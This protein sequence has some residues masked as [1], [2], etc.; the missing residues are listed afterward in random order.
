[1]VQNNVGRGDRAARDSC[2]VPSIQ[3][4]KTRGGAHEAH[5][6]LKTSDGGNQ[7][8]GWR[9][10]IAGRGTWRWKALA[11]TEASNNSNQASKMEV[12][13]RSVDETEPVDDGS[14]SGPGFGE[15][16]V[17]RLDQG[18]ALQIRGRFLANPK[19]S[20][21]D[22]EGWPPSNPKSSGNTLV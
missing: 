8:A 9:S 15:A 22:H 18:K 7:S 11:R 21:R 4:N 2:R 17:G 5:I 16:V 13:G 10:W 1:M 14:G 6:V 19:Q 3:P 12:G 20:L